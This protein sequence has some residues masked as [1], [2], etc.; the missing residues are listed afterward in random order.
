MSGKARGHRASSSR[1]VPAI[2]LAL[3]GARKQSVEKNDLK[4]SER[5]D[6][7]HKLRY[8]TTSA[9][10]SSDQHNVKPLHDEQSAKAGRH[11]RDTGKEQGGKFYY[12]ILT[13]AC[14][15]TKLFLL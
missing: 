8:N 13:F 4:T 10:S 5:S 9:S 2:P 1:V 15:W 11:Y 6:V 14:S 3:G 12:M 7:A